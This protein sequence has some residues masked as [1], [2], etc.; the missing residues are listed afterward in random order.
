MTV[1][2]W[3]NGTNGSSLTQLSQPFGISITNNNVLYISDTNNNRIVIV[4]LTS[5]TNISIIGSGPGSNPTQFNMPFNLFLTHTSL[6]VIE[7]INL[8]LQ[9][10]PLNGSNPSTVV[11][12]SGFDWA[13][14]F[15]VDGD[16]NIYVS[17]TQNDK[18][19]FFR[20]NTTNWIIVAGTGVVGANDN[21][22]N[23]P[24]GVFVSSN[25]TLYVADCYNYRIMKWY[26][27]ALTGIR[28]A[29]D[30][31]PGMSSTQLN[32][33]TQ[34]I[35]DVNENMYISER[36]N[37]RITR[38]NANASFGECIAACTGIAG[39]ARTE[40]N[41]PHSLAFDS[42]G[43]LYVSDRQNHRIQKFQFLSYRKYYIRNQQ[44]NSCDKDKFHRLRS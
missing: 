38:W 18:V 35:V 26:S 29:G 41:A 27:G 23:G 6:Y 28:V 2:G 36:D 11:S 9:K 7:L 32:C 25:Q 37:S 1:A 13:I 3:P 16:E 20:A 42:A 21:Q 15:Y 31:T 8:R 22:L 4:D 30:G 33:P 14:F 43:S 19:V 34:I 5:N 10:V 44:S 40:L 17:V 12:M 39:S 24:F